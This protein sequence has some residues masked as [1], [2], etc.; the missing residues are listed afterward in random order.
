M[1]WFYSQRG[2]QHGPVGTN[3]IL[4]KIWIGEL[5]PTDLAWR[6]G[7]GGWQAISSIPELQ[8]TQVIAGPPTLPEVGN[9]GTDSPYK[10]PAL[11]AGVRIST[12]PPNYMWQAIV[13]TLFCCLP[14]GIPAII[15]ASQVDTMKYRGDI[16]GARLASAKARFWFLLSA[17]VTV[18]IILLIVLFFG[19]S[20]LVVGL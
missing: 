13:V 18:G 16:D 11:R 7:M 8:A 15:Y 1:E 2:K 4:Q 19:V 6:A 17:G 10:P 5:H 14:L 9:V 12:E 3:E 20:A